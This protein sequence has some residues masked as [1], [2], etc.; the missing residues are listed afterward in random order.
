MSLDPLD[1]DRIPPWSALL[2]AAAATLVGLLLAGLLPA[3]AVMLLAA[4]GLLLA[5]VFAAVHHAEVLALR[6]GEPFGSLLLALSITVI[7]VALILALMLSAPDGSATLARD[8]VYATVMLVLTVIVGSCLLFG[9]V[10]HGEQ[11]FR[12]DSAT[13]ALSVLGTIAVICLVLP[14]VTR[15]TVGPT[16]ASLQLVVVGLVSMTLYGVFLFVQTI[17]HRVYF[18]DPGADP[19]A[20]PGLRPSARTALFS[21][22]LLLLSLVSIVLLAKTLSPT[23]ERAVEQAGLPSAFVGVI[24]AAIVL[25]PESLSALRAARNNRLQMSVNLALGSALATIGMTIPVVGLLAL[26]LDLPMELGLPPT[27]A[28]LLLLALFISGISLSTGRTTV[29]QGAVHLGIGVVFLTMAALP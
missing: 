6:L 22:G 4:A 15:S 29:L 28:A 26:W 18:L 20:E 27:E 7:E 12:L 1:I 16:F 23:L 24:I 2:P 5:S 11:V 10:R 9:G 8:T 17:R 25:L 3:S 13:A 14:D 21:L 19:Q